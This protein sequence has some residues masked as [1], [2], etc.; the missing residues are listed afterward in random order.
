MHFHEAFAR[1]LA[2]QGITEVFGV[3]GEANMYIMSSFERVTAGRYSSFSNEEG[4]V[5]AADGYARTSGRLGVATVTHGPGLTNTVTALVEAV[6]NRTP[7]LLVAGDTALVDRHNLQK[8]PQREV[9][10]ATG[11]GFEQVRAADTYA[12]DIA[13][14][15]RRAEVERRPIVLTVPFDLQWTEVAYEPVAGR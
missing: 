2:D 4:A 11:A 1:A 14:A 9:V 7:L 8:I 13:V 6:R 3:L 15:V 5:L 12:E 10:V